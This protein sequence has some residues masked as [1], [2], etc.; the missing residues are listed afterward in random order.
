MVD[1]NET[2]RVAAVVP[3][4]FWTDQEQDKKGDFVSV[5]YVEWQK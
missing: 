3:L 2:E 1:L 5:D 4:N